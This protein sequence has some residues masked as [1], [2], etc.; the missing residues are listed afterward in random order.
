MTFRLPL[1][2]QPIRLIPPGWTPPGWV[3]D[4]ENNIFTPPGVRF[5]TVKEA[6]EVASL[7]PAYFPR[8]ESSELTAYFALTMLASSGSRMA[9]IREVSKEDEGPIV[10][11]GLLSVR[12]HL[13]YGQ[14]PYIDVVVSPEHSAKEDDL[15]LS[16]SSFLRE[17]AV[18]EEF[19]IARIR[20]V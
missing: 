20:G 10:A 1:Y 18:S 19:P 13:H 3:E 14:I 11:V 9:C 16:L 17:L 12:N 2:S 8:G 5:F 7:C 4:K 6:V 15:R